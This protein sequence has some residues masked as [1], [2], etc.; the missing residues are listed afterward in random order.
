MIKKTG[1]Q[2]FKLTKPKLINT[3]AVVGPFEGKGPLKEFYDH[4]YEDNLMGEA[5]F[6]RAE[7]QMLLNACYTC[8][9]KAKKTPGDVDL[10]ISGD[11]LNQI[12]TSGF[13]ALELQIPYLGIYG[14][15]STC[16]EGLALAS[17]LIEGN[18]ANIILAATSSH[19]STAE[20]Q[21]RYPTEY[22][23]KEKPTSQRTVSGAGAA[24]VADE[25]DGPRITFATIGK[26]TDLGIKDTNS[27]GAAMAPAAAST[28]IQHF[29]DTGH[30]PDYYDAILSGDLGKIGKK[31]TIE[32][33]K[34]TGG[35]DISSNFDDCGLMIYDME[36][37]DVQ[38]GASGC[39]SSA[40]V[41]YGYVYKKMLE[42]KLDRVLL[43][44]TGALYSTTSFQ[45]GENI[46]TIAHAVSLEMN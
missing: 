42:G 1:K 14:A 45:Q 17:M 7:K 39:A 8:L 46:P 38:A 13:S 28:L 30:G 24:L 20:R 6:E 43:V 36:K 11:L 32:L 19:Y 41:T 23:I 4:I 16:A 10:Y 22:G 3:A 34:K 21:F 27:V 35:F 37:Q 15:C 44:A 2:T 12:I 31:L 33:V 18:M 26:V 9:N 40:V 25:G 29:A 5:S